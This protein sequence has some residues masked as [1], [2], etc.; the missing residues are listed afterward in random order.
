MKPESV[1]LIILILI[2]MLYNY[3]VNSKMYNNVLEGMWSATEEFCKKSE[4]DGMIVYIGPKQ[5]LNKRKAYLIIHSDN[6]IISSEEMTISTG[7]GFPGFLAQ[8][9]TTRKIKIETDLDI[10]PDDLIME[11]DYT[12]KMIW[13]AEND[14]GEMTSYADLLKDNLSTP[15]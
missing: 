2:I 1:L 10:M 5:K 9:K 7:I 15:E 13:R 12:G 6:T 14:D 3:N 8:S 4:I 11:L